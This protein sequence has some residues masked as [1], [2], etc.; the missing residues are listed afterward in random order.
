M[1]FYKEGKYCYSSLV[2]FVFFRQ[3]TGSE[4]LSDEYHTP[5]KEKF[6]ETCLL[7]EG[8]PFSSDA[9][10]GKLLHAKGIFSESLDI[11]IFMYQY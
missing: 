1:Y 10:Q 6:L 5:R 2:F 3:E 11:N 4:S 8:I 9:G 7:P